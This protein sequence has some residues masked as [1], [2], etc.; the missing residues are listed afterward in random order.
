MQSATAAKLASLSAPPARGLSRSVVAILVLLSA[1]LV[2]YYPLHYHPFFCVDDALYVTANP[3][4]LGPLNASSLAWAFTHAYCLNYDPLTF[5]AHSLD[6]RLFQLNPSGHHDVNVALHCLDV[7]LL[8]WVLKRATG[9]VG[10]SF[11][12]AALFALHPINVE[13]VAWVWPPGHWRGQAPSR[14]VRYTVGAS[15]QTLPRR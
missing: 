13:N 8:F 14:K 7:I 3:H 2:V 12:V 15:P 10:R 6:L 11:I 9:Y 4:V 5:V 1:T